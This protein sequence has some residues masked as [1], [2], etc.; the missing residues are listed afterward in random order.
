ME[1]NEKGKAKA[2]PFYKTPFAKHERRVGTE[3]QTH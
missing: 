1:N 3:L 2:F